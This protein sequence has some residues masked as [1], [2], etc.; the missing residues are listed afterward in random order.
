MLEAAQQN[1]PALAEL[2]CVFI[3]DERRAS[4]G[5]GHLVKCCCRPTSK[6]ADANAALA[7]WRRIKRPARSPRAVPTAP[8]NVVQLK[9]GL[10]EQPAA[11]RVQGGLP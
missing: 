5:G 2:F 8:G 10:A 9:L 1:S 11:K 4:A 7:E 3:H 6:K